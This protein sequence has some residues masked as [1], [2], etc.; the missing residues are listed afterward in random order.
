MHPSTSI[1]MTLP[2]SS[3]LGSIVHAQ[4]IIA[5][6]MKSELFATCFPTQMR[7][8]NPYVKWPS[9]FV[10]GVHDF[11][12]PLASMNVAGLKCAASAP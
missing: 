2:F 4:S 3:L 1:G 9:S 5:K 7:H 8:P 11:T 10:S 12:S 6:S